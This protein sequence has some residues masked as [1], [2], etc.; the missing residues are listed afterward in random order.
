MIQKMQFCKNFCL[1]VSQTEAKI[2]RNGLRFTSN[3]SEEKIQAK[4]GHPRRAHSHL[5]KIREIL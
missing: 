1:F 2:M 3:G 4:K 5:K